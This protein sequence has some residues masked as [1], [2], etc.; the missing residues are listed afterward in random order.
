[1]LLMSTIHY[2]IF[3]FKQENLSLG[4]THAVKWSSSKFHETLDIYLLI[5][6]RV[7]KVTYNK[8][9]EAEMHV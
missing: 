8:R 6:A 5:K 3:F 1:M 4:A 7:S 2:I 9:M